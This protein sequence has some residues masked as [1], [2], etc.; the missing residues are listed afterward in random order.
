MDFCTR[1]NLNNLPDTSKDCLY[2]FPV[3]YHHYFLSISPSVNYT[4]RE[5]VHLVSMYS[6]V[7]CDM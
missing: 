4:V 3:S 6:H 7:M 1:H 5:H 2:S